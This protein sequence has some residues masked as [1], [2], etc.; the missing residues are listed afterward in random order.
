[1]MNTLLILET[2]QNT[3]SPASRSVI[4]AAEQRVASDI[5]G[6]EIHAC[7][8]CPSLTQT[9]VTQPQVT[10]TRI[11]TE[12]P[13][14]TQIQINLQAYPQISKFIVLRHKAALPALTA[15]DWVEALSSLAKNYDC[16]MAPA[17]TFGKNI[18]PRL[19]GHLMVP[20][21]SDVIEILD[22]QT[23]KRPIY[24]GNAIETVQCV[25]KPLL[26]TIRPAA[27]KAITPAA[28]AETP[29][30]TTCEKTTQSGMVAAST[31][32]ERVIET[33]SRLSQVLD[34][35]SATSDRPE[36]ATA[37]WVVAGGRGLQDRERFD[38]LATIASK[39]GAA[40]GASRA[41]VD[42]GFA[43]NEYQVGQTGQVIAPQVYIAVGISG[44]IQHLAGIKASKI[45]VVINK[46]PDAPIC[47][48]ADY[49]LIADIDTVLPEWEALLN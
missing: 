1:M 42:A 27:F 29:A 12:T 2:H 38:R 25:A 10:Q 18:L 35:Q 44:A 14:K 46:D 21:L 30:S 19:A 45:I 13:V 26:M 7:F 15:E 17:N 43:P 31:V 48:L 32:V 20:Q 40:M 24:A 36:L 11:K 37:S 23:I 22:P 9:Q 6:H 41:A 39:M 8:A 34:Q 33:P 16:I 3:L 47:E 49:R 28:A 4:A 5:K